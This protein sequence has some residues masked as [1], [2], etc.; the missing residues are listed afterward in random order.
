MPT[1]G[2]YIWNG[3]MELDKFGWVWGLDKILAETAPSLCKERSRHLAY[4]G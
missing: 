2:L 3:F 4:S 1:L